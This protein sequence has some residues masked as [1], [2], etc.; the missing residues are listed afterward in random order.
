MPRRSEANAV[1]NLEKL[2]TGLPAAEYVMNVTVLYDDA[3]TRRQ[4]GQLYMKVESLLGRNALR[5]SWWKLADLVQPGVLA[6]AVS[7]AIRSD[8]IVLA[9]RSSEGLP[10][11][12]YYWVNAWLPHRRTGTGALVGLLSAPRTYNRESGRLRKYLKTVAL[13]AR[14]DLL[15]AESGMEVPTP[16]RSN[17]RLENEGRF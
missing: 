4:A 8:M 10:L 11:P 16:A 17:L 6:G 13:R 9:V 2:V 14:M 1:G 5:G 12:F 7:K 3:Q 15:V